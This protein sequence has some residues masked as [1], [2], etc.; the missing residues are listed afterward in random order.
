MNKITSPESLCVTLCD[1]HTGIGADGIVLIRISLRA[2]ARMIS[3]NR[4]GTRA[5]IGGNNLRFMAKYLYDQGIVRKTNMSIET[6]V[7]VRTMHLFLRNGKVH[8]VTVDMGRP[9]FAC[10]NIPVKTEEKEMIQ[11][12]LTIHEHIYTV[13]CV[14]VGSPNCVIFDDHIE[15]IN[16]QEVGPYFENADLFPERTNTEFVRVVDESTLKVRVYERGNGVTNGCGID[17]CAAAA[18]AVR[19]GYCRDEMPIKVELPGGSVT[20]TIHNGRVMLNGGCETVFEGTF[21]Y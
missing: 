17:A 3:Y 12:P 5:E 4:D 18:A 2:D 16:L 19:I 9:D 11:K 14:K 8:S 1:R 6:D 21:A 20:V 10:E 13:T 15:E 7:G